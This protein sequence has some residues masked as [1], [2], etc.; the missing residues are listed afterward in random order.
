[1]LFG[2]SKQLVYVFPGFYNKET[3]NSNRY[4]CGK[5]RSMGFNPGFKRFSLI[6]REMVDINTE[7][8]SAKVQKF[9]SPL[10]FPEQE[11]SPLSFFC[12]LGHEN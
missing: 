11:E 7:V 12:C 5:F 6:R 3:I 10:W 9:K 8:L 4:N 2:M 1:M